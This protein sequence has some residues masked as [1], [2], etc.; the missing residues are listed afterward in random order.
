MGYI[1]RLLKLP[2]PRASDSSAA[3]C[4]MLAARASSDCRLLRNQDM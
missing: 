3:S 2:L 1:S 4:A